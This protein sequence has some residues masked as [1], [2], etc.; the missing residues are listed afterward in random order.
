MIERI[1]LLS[2]PTGGVWPGAVALRE[3]FRGVERVT[4][5]EVRRA[6]TDALLTSVYRC[7]PYGCRAGTTDDT[8]GKLYVYD[9]SLFEELGPNYP[10]FLIS[11]AVWREEPRL[12]VAIES[13]LDLLASTLSV[14]NRTGRIGSIRS[15]SKSVFSETG[16]ITTT[17]S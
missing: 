4:I 6:D 13:R 14:F 9:T 8:L 15:R 10:R 12:D 17:M 5:S 16:R 3:A 1:V 11:N 7:E 2:L